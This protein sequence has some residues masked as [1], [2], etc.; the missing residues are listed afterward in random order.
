MTEEERKTE[1]MARY[2]R[3]CHAMQS[4]V[5]MEMQLG[6]RNTEPKHLRV[7]INSAMVEHSAV[8]RLLIEKSII[9]EEEY[10]RSLAVGM[11]QEVKSYE[12]RLSEM[13]GGKTVTLL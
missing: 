3:A 11:E 9:T 8:A 7:G 2:E 5:A 4:G 12:K 1:H 10:L 13:L 6:A